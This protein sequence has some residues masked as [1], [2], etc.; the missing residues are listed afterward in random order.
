MRTSR[1]WCTYEDSRLDEH[2]D[3]RLLMEEYDGILLFELT[4][5][6]CESPFGTLL[7][8]NHSTTNPE[9]LLASTLGRGHPYL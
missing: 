4:D 5:Q 2:N 3:F 8:W 6:Q 9:L 7:N 1:K